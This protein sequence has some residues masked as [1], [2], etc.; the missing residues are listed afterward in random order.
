M[1]YAI[2]LDLS[3][4]RIASGII[5][6]DGDLIQ[7]EVLG[8]RRSEHL[9]RYQEAVETIKRVLRHSSIPRREMKGIGIGLPIMPK[10]GNPEKLIKQVKESSQINDV[11]IYDE[12][13]IIAFA[14]WKKRVLSAQ[15]RF[16]YILVQTDI[17]CVIIQNGRRL[18]QTGVTPQAV[19]P[20]WQMKDG[21][22]KKQLD[23]LAGTLA[24]YIQEMDRSIQADKIVFGGP[25][26]MIYPVLLKHIKEKL[27]QEAYT[28]L[29]AKLH[30]CHLTPDQRLIGAGLLV[31]NR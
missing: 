23:Q 31:L 28:D 12:A 26:M 13:S 1:E 19:L 8:S 3:G 20:N 15:Q 14:E 11:V 6:Q 24:H 21:K 29:C 16:V 2:G 5:N 25:L 9:T 4:R 7:K 30:L 17:T 18:N 10:E 22:P 27:K